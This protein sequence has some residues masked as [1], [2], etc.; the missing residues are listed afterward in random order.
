MLGA[1]NAIDLDLYTETMTASDSEGE[2][3]LKVTFDQVHCVDRVI[4]FK[5]NGDPRLT[6]ICP[7]KECSLTEDSVSIV[8]PYSV[9]VSSSGEP[10]AIPGSGCSY[11]DTVKLEN[12]NANMFSLFE[13][14][15]I[16]KGNI[17]IYLQLK[18]LCQIHE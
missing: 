12:K 8:D 6:W 15:V 11:G 13:I 3:W 7:E 17:Q 18:L 1:A 9:S 14:A 4:W 5:S 10:P 2:A 16:E